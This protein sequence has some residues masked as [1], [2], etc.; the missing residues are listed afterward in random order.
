M[1]YSLSLLAIQCSEPDS[2]LSE[3]NMARTGQ[4]CEYA[5]GPLSGYA[6]PDGWYLVVAT[7]CNHR[8][9]KLSELGRVSTKFPVIACSIE[10]H[11]MFSS[12][13]QWVSGSM[14]WRAEH[15]GENGPINLKT[16]GVLPPGFQ[17][18]TDALAAQQQADGGEKANVDHYFDI[19]L[20]AAKAIIGF[21][22]DEVVP[23]VNYDNFDQLSQTGSGSNGKPWWR[24]WG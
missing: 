2:A 7:K 6:L 23:G 1:G 22:H 24:F 11:V 16:S 17:A 10:E 5:R 14:L 8:F 18:M 20:N 3:L 19:P 13:E 4:F 12:A 15:V 21:K 9:L